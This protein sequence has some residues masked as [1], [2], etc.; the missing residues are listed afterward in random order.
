MDDGEMPSRRVLLKEKLG[1]R[2]EPDVW[3]EG[4]GNWHSDLNRNGS[5]S[6][7]NLTENGV[8]AS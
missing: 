2:V 7:V 1:Y 3:Q 5:R 4:D 6:G 8:A